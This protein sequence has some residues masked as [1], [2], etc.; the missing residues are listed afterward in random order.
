MNSVV[1]H[2][3]TL[4]LA[5]VLFTSLGAVTPSEASAQAAVASPKTDLD[6]NIQG[7][8]G[9]GLVG[10]ELG[11]VV[12]AAFG[13]DGIWTWLVFP[14]ALGAGG[15]VAGPFLI[16]Q[17]NEVGAGVGVLVGG[18][19]LLVPSLVLTLALTAYDPDEDGRIEKEEIPTAYRGPGDGAGLVRYSGDGA[20]RVALPGVSYVPAAVT[21]SGQHSEVHVPVLSGSF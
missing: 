17:N 18:M 1:R 4:G 9:L 5:A 12:P 14:V 16:D 15:A 3:L 8:V 21:D 19:A 10:A 20:L 13:L 2:V 6:S 7:L 11:M